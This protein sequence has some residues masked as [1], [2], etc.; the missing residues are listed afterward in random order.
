MTSDPTTA[1]ADGPRPDD[2]GRRALDPKAARAVERVELSM[3]VAPELFAL[4][5][6]LVSV[7]ASRLDFD[8]EDVCDLRLAVDEL[9]TLCTG[10][11]GED[12]RITLW[13]SHD[14]DGLRIEC[15]VSPAAAPWV[16]STTSEP[17]VAGLAPAELSERILDVLSDGHGTAYEATS[18]TRTGWLWKLRPSD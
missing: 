13:S 17:D 11:H 9:V 8:Y 3:P 6:M 18:A 10:G 5:R 1:T 16:P 12:A 4:V 7:V 14:P 2:E 15:A